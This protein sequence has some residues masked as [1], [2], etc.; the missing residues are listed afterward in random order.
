M[1]SRDDVLA[2]LD[3][4]VGPVAVMDLV[5]RDLVATPLRADLVPV[6]EAAERRLGGVLVGAAIG[7]ALG[8]GVRYETS[9]AIAARRGRVRD[10]LPWSGWRGGSVGTVLAEGQELLMYARAFVDDRAT[11]W[12]RFAAG[13]PNAMPTQRDPGQATIDAS[14]RLA[15]G[16]PWFAAGTDSFG[17]GG[18]LRA[19][20]DALAHPG[21]PMWRAVSASL[22]AAVTH[23]H[24]RAVVASV[25]AADAI[26]TLALDPALASDPM[27]FAEILA[28]RCP[29]PGLAVKLRTLA[30]RLNNCEPEAEPVLLAALAW[31]LASPDAETAL[32]S[33]ASAG[34]ATHLVAGLVGA[35]AAARWGVESYPARWFDDLEG[36]SEYDSL[37]RDPGPRDRTA[38]V[39]ERER[40]D[41]VEGAGPRVVPARSVRL[42]AVHLARSGLR[43]P[44]VRRGASGQSRAG[45]T[46]ARAVRR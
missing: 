32:V 9:Q 37:R 42:D 3:R 35:M 19:A 46:H 38:P 21:D 13:L 31:A 33:A 23:A 17:A 6:S 7:N 26:A 25:V 29:D 11:P 40:H 5:G 43:A 18:I 27:A 22:G 14:R 36:R 8:R 30:T 10:F 15:Q 24:R 2:E 4:R 12:A 28:A 20:V 16:A 41:V 44:H 45:A 1:T 39:V 34:G